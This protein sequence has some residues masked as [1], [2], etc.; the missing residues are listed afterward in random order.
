M[1]ILLEPLEHFSSP[2]VCK[3]WELHK[4]G[5]VLGVWR[6]SATDSGEIVHAAHRGGKHVVMQANELNSHSTNCVITLTPNSCIDVSLLIGKYSV[7][8]QE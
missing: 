4:C 8:D 2:P 1:L 7:S 3:V 5:S 6:L